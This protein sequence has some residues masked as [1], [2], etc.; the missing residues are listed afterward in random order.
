MLARARGE[1][2]RRRTAVA[3]PLVVAFSRALARLRVAALRV[4]LDRR[5]VVALGGAPLAALLGGAPL[6]ALLGVALA[7]ALAGC[8]GAGEGPTPATA[9]AACGNAVRESGEEC[10]DGNASNADACLTTCQAPASFVPSD[11]HVHGYGCSATVTPAE[12]EARLRAQQI[13]VAAA[14]V[15]GEGWAIDR[16]FFT[17]RDHPVSSPDL[18]L[19]YDL[20][21]SRFVAARTG[22]LLLLGLDS[23]DFSSDVFF[24]PQSGVPIVEWARR[25]PRAVVGMAHA[26][27][28]PADGSYPVP[29]GGC[30]V[31]WELV[32]HA[33]RGRLDFLS[34]ERMFEEEPGS[35]VL[36]KALQNAGLR[37]AITGG[38]D[39]SCLADRFHDRTPR[40]DVIVDGPLTYESWLQAIKTGRTVAAAGVGHRLNLR[41]ER[42]RLGEEIALSAP[43]EVTAT[44]ETVGPPGEVQVLVNGAVAAR[45]PVA[46]GAQVA[47]VRLPVAASSWVAART[48]YAVT[49]PVYVI[50][51]GRPVRASAADAC[52]LRRYV[53]H[54]RNLVGSGGVRLWE[55]EEEA[56]RAY[57][58][59]EQ[60]LQR[61]FVESGGGECR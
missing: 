31:P 52:Y 56:L 17:G 60:E 7:G 22:H 36:W 57:D 23:I 25:Q 4:A 10:D 16:V 8:G 34:M 3:L 20:E 46:A 54:L 35:F 47:Q 32:V 37:V 19:H 5:L 18:L 12:L 44:V 55:S 38:S 26:Q 53:Q 21:V 33:A 43:G 27:W 39:W 9:A 2:G 29:P 45:V 13:R 40:T 59:A 48:P 58:E 6:A 42:R 30:C 1:G 50:V 15:W 11:V 49:S 41:V 24:V 14:L 28:W 61:R 51:A